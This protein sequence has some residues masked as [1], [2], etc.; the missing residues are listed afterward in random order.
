MK[1]KKVTF[2]LFLNKALTPQKER[3]PVYFRIT[4][5]RQNTKIPDVLMNEHTLYWSQDDLDAFERGYYS[6]KTSQATDMVKQS[7][8]FYED[9]IRYE[10]KKY[11]DN[12]SIKGLADRARFFRKSFSE[13]FEKQLSY[14]L[15]MENCLN[16]TAEKKMDSIHLSHLHSVIEE[17]KEQLSRTFLRMLETSILLD[18]YAMPYYNQQYSYSFLADS[19]YHWTLNGGLQEFKDF[20]HRFFTDKSGLDESFL[21]ER[22][23]RNTPEQRYLKP[24]LQSTPPDSQLKEVYVGLL[25]Q[26]LASTM[27]Q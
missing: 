2:K 12:Y 26:H 1:R 24:L 11:G 10:A 13:S 6:E 8:Q 9:I 16:R 18:L 27:T 14:L 7:M 20:V 5:N 4:Y 15:D 19:I 17:K 21:E 22:L 3:Y 25:E 23:S